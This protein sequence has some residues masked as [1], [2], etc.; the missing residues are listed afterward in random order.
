VIDPQGS[1]C[2]EFEPLNRAGGRVP[3]LLDE[4]VR[5][6]SLN[7][8]VL[9]CSKT[10]SIP[11]RDLDRGSSV[12]SD[13]LRL[14]QWVAPVGGLHVIP[15]SRLICGVCAGA[16]PRAAAAASCLRLRLR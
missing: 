12:S 15:P 14:S 13:D 1:T 16:R 5:V 9:I 8:P 11:P 6:V 10:L 2:A 4:V 3:V 7:A